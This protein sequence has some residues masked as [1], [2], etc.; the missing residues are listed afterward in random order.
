MKEVKQSTS[1]NFL[2]KIKK[3]LT[4]FKRYDIINIS[5]ENKKHLK[6]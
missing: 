4:N 5:K 2:K 3:V 6:K 1:K